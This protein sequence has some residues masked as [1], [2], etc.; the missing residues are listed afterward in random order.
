MRLVP[1]RDKLSHTLGKLLN[2]NVIWSA[3]LNALVVLLCGRYRYING[4]Y[5]TLDCISVYYIANCL[6]A[7]VSVMV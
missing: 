7:D 2:E 1:I 4:A 5:C 3:V 6:C